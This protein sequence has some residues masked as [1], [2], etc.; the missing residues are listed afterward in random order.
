MT[1]PIFEN[2][3]QIRLKSDT[4]KI[5]Q[6]MLQIFDIKADIIRFI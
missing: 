6:Y 3:R 1:I 2:N 5:A 4:F